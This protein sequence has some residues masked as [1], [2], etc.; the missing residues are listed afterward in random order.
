MTKD[1]AE[2]AN[3]QGDLPRV[4]MKA[5]IRSLKYTAQHGDNAIERFNALLQLERLGETI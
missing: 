4:Q 3:S 5:A 1:F 2:T